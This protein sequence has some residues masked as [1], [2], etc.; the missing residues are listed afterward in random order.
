[1]KHEKTW[2]NQPFQLI[3]KP[4]RPVQRIGFA[5]FVTMVNTH[6][7]VWLTFIP[8]W[9]YYAERVGKSWLIPA[10]EEYLINKNN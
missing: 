5:R 10:Y 6:N 4:E 3:K 9:Q 1:M 2:N 8:Q 7:L